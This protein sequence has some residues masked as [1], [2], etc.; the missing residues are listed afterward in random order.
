MIN[1]K[2][3][4]FD[5]LCDA[6]DNMEYQC[7]NWFPSLEEIKTQLEPNIEKEIKFAIWILQTSNPQTTK[8]GKEARRYLMNLVYA[9]LNIT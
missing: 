7:G 8:E 1:M 4:K 3:E 5:K 2:Q 6:Y 9:H